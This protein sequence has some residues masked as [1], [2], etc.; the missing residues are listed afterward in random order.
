MPVRTRGFSWT[1][2]WTIRAASIALCCLLLAAPISRAQSPGGLPGFFQNL[3]NPSPPSQAAKRPS[4]TPL[5]VRAHK[6][7]ARKEEPASARRAP[8]FVATT[9]ARAPGA[10][11]G[12]PAGPTTFV[13]VLGDSLAIMASQGLTE[14]FSDRPEAS[15]TVLARDLSGLTR[16]DYYDWP[17]AARALMA[18]NPKIDAAV[19][20]IGLNDL[21]PMSADGYMLDTLSDEWRAKYGERIE[22]FVAPFHDAH[23]PVYWIGLPP[24]QDEKVNSEVLAL[25]ELYRDHAQKAGA[26]YIDISEAFA[27]ENGRYAAFGPDVEGQN[28]KL[29]AGPDGMYLTKAGSRKL[30][31]FLEADI[32]RMLDKDKPPQGDIAALPPDI[33]QQADDI[34]AQIRREMGLELGGRPADV[35]LPARPLAGPIL[36]LTAHPTSPGGELVDAKAQATGGPIAAALQPG[37][38]PEP[39]P[40]RADDFSWPRPQQP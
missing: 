20:M 9:T 13:S 28:A 12:A 17:K 2:T 26:T 39:E 4:D 6:S 30:A 35:V 40:G 14:A 21:Q 27:D 11:G 25:N 32:R 7:G 22:S 8:D 36:S 10:P 1:P 37:A 3:F 23:V 5:G 19:I 38:V 15:F 24:M 33:E 29:R 34:N 31:H 16:D 18:R